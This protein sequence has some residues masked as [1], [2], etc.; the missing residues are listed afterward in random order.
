MNFSPQ[1]FVEASRNNIIFFII[2]ENN[3]QTKLKYVL[4]YIP[5]RILKKK[6][7]LMNAMAHLWK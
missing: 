3:S 6:K 2:Q 4:V 5:V 7:Q 1:Y